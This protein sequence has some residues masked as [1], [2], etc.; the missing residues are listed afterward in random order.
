MSLISILLAYHGV[1]KAQL[2]RSYT[3]SDDLDL[4][5][6][7]TI[8]TFARLR[9]WRT[10]NCIDNDNHFDTTTLLRFVLFC[11]SPFT[12]TGQLFDFGKRQHSLH[13]FTSTEIL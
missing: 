5:T 3:A 10:T 6:A 7:Y 13:D 8:T 1:T 4:R 9:S 12:F 11:F 2:P